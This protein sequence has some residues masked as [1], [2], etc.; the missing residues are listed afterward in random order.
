MAVAIS[1]GNVNINGAS[2]FDQAE[3]HNLSMFSATELALTSTRQINFT[4]TTSRNS[5]GVILS[6]VPSAATVDRSVQ[7]QLRL[8]AAVLQTA[9]LTA[10]SIKNSVTNATTGEWIAYF[11]Y[12]DTALTAS[13]VYNFSITQTGGTTGNW[14]LKTSDAT[15][16]F[17]IEVPDKPYTFVNDDVLV[18]KPGDQVTIN[19]SFS[20]KG[21]L[22]TGDATNGVAAVIGKSSAAITTT[23]L[24][25]GLIWSAAPASAYT[26]TV[27]G[28]VILGAHSGFRRGTSASPIPFAQQSSISWVNRTIGT[29]ASGMYGTDGAVTPAVDRGCSVFAFGEVPAVRY[30]TLNGNHAAGATALTVNETPTGWQ[31]GNRLFIGKQN[32]AG[33]GN[34]TLHTIS[35]IV[36]NTI[37]ISPALATNQRMSG[38]R[39]V[40]VDA[41]YGVRE[42][43]NTT[44]RAL[45]RLSVASNLSYVGCLLDEVRIQTIWTPTANS[46]PLDD[47]ANTSR[48]DF[49]DTVY[50]NAGTASF[51]NLISTMNPPQ[52]GLLADEFYAVNGTLFNESSSHVVNSSGPCVITNSYMTNPNTGRQYLL[53]NGIVSDTIIENTSSSC[54][55]VLA[56]NWTATDNTFWGGVTGMNLLTGTISAAEVANNTYNRNTVGMSLLSD[57][58]VAVDTD[59]VFGNEIANTTD[60]RIAAGVYAK[61]NY[62]SNTGNLVVNSSTT[63]TEWLPGTKLRFSNFNDTL[64]DYRAYYQYGNFLNS[65]NNLQL[66]PNSGSSELASRYKLGSDS[67][68]GSVLYVKS[69]C[70]IA[71]TAYDAGT[72]VF[73]K[74]RLTYDGG[75]VSESTASAIFGSSQTLALSVTPV[76]DNETLFIDITGQT[77]ATSPNN[78]VTFTPVVVRLRSYGDTFQSTTLTIKETTDDRVSVI[79]TPVTN[80]FITVTNRATVAAYTEFTIDHVAQ[81]I[82]ITADTT[83][84]RLYDYTQFD[85]TETANLG[86]DEWY[87]TNDGSTFTSTYDFILNTGVDLTGGGTIDVGANTFTRTGTATYDGIVATSTNRVVHITLT[88]LVAGSVVQVYNTS[89]SAEIVKTTASSSTYDYYYTWTS[90]INIRVRVRYVSGVT[91]YEPFEA[92]GTVTSTGFALAVSQVAD[93]VYNANNFDGSTATEFSMSEGVIKIFVDDP[94]NIT[95]GQRL[96][97]WYLYSISTTSFIDDQ[98]DL[99]EAQTPWS[100]V[101]DDTLLIENL[102]T[103]NPLYIFGA[104][105]N[106]ESSNGQ[107]IDTSGGSININGYFPFNSAAD[108][109]SAVVSDGQTLTVGKFLALK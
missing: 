90:N 74:L 68:S 31:N 88:G 70:T 65:G 13:T 93:A 42:T 67:I 109:A 108:V 84:D 107:V 8:V 12:T 86:Y 85:L 21:A 6:L 40:N 72:Y 32:V 89:G 15:N 83:M 105:I 47:T 77:D 34:A 43:G 3:N 24:N 23:S 102:D 10:S 48:W 73:P 96:Y 87:T 38:G 59:S 60:V 9:T 92:T 14:S 49:S 95:T 41:G 22:G 50:S 76:N 54:L 25:E 78:L 5:K 63:Q 99:V 101:L 11:D 62:T 37:N 82:T 17:F 94:N 19:A 79:T 7:V 75:T 100:Y 66:Y 29:T 98:A 1:N 53:T 36:G 20:I 26:M 91:G 56:T 4:P 61:Y 16:P 104:N 45:H 39:V 58:G 106:N 28:M 103:A 44:N 18:V 69:D 55:I 57:I 52:K 27:D 2:A 30:V 46:V 80:P 97:N 33:Q 51:Y 71:N 35:S 81:T 64:N